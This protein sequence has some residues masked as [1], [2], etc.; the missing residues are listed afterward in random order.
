MVPF[1]QDFKDILKTLQDQEDRIAEVLLAA[2]R[3]GELNLERMC[4]V[5]INHDDSGKLNFMKSKLEV[6]D[7]EGRLNQKG[8]NS[9]KVIRVLRTLLEDVNE[10]YE[11]KDRDYELFLQQYKRLTINNL[12]QYN[13]VLYSGEMIDE[14][15]CQDNYEGFK[16]KGEA[17]RY[18]EICDNCYEARDDRLN[19]CTCYRSPEK[20]MR[21]RY[22]ETTSGEL[23]VDVDFEREDFTEDDYDE[24]GIE[25]T[26]GSSCMRYYRC[27]YENYFEVYKRNAKLLVLLNKNHEI[28]GRAIV[29]QN[30]QCFEHDLVLPYFMDRIYSVDEEIDDLMVAYARKMQWAYKREQSAHAKEGIYYFNTNEASYEKGA[31]RM[32]VNIEFD[33]YN[34]APYMDTFSIVYADKEGMWL[35]NTDR[36]SNL[37]NWPSAEWGSTEGYSRMKDL[38]RYCSV[39]NK[40]TFAAKMNN[41]ITEQFKNSVIKIK[42]KTECI[43]DTCLNKRNEYAKTDKIHSESELQYA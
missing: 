26:L 28:Q 42:P 4:Y 2:E 17:E 37:D 43:C 24:D 29:W 8:L 33:D 1:S 9:G 15:Y 18:Y 19:L 31:F 14:G 20:E 35:S 30:V 36:A 21:N 12:D 7:E 32:R 25:H 16:H 40:Y 23:R 5:M 34:R 11:L 38:K 10:I 3:K 6:F 39:C 41:I 22:R 27:I 13:F